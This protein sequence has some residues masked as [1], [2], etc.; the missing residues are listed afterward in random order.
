[1]TEREETA[2]VLETVEEWRT[3]GV[4]LRKA[5]EGAGLSR[6]EVAQ[7]LRLSVT[8]ITHLEES[9]FDRFPAPIFV[10]GYLRK[11][12]RLLGIPSDPLVEAFDRRGLEPPSL[13]A[14]LTSEKQEPAKRR[15]G[16]DFDLRAEYWAAILVGVG[17]LILL[18]VW[19]FSDEEEDEPLAAQ[20]APPAAETGPAE[21]PQVELL[22]GETPAPL[23]APAAIPSV[24]PPAAMVAAPAP[25]TIPAERTAD[26]PE[27]R[28]EGAGAEV[29]QAE[30]ATAARPSGDR[31]E[32]RF[33]A[34]S[35]VEIRDSTG[36]RLMYDLAK[37]GQARTLEGT[38]PF[39]ILLGYAPGV[40]IEYNGEPYDFSRH[41]RGRVARFQ[42]GEARDD[43]RST[44]GVADGTEP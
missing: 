2:P 39:S 8:Q 5:R 24:P 16:L 9:R 44:L 27:S 30:A 29:Q 6:E 13:H 37:A 1:M 32:L 19:L 3:I 18:L 38:P 17:V 15:F 22:A 42:L 26:V 11:Y 7:E 12:A 35:W 43:S 25:E 21:P 33:S 28:P 14:E 31:L 41:V 36:R 34:E 20:E 4:R 40:E 10:K 23:S